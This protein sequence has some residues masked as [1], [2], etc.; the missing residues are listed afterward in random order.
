MINDTQTL[1]MTSIY[2]GFVG[3]ARAV[4]KGEG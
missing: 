2:G 1:M 4:C 3:Q